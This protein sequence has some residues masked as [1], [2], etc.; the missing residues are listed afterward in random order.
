MSN[1]PVN[2]AIWS[3]SDLPP[4]LSLSESGLLTGHPTTSGSYTSHVQVQTNWGIA[5]KTISLTVTEPSYGAEITNDNSSAISFYYYKSGSYTFYASYNVPNN[6]SSSTPTWT[7]SGLP[8]GLTNSSLNAT[9]LTISGYPTVTGNYTLRLTFTKGSYTASKKF[10]LSVTSDGKS[11]S[12]STSS[13]PS[14]VKGESYSATLSVN[15]T[16]GSSPYYYVSGLPSGLSVGGWSGT[17]SGTPS[18][19]GTST[20]SIY[21]TA[22]NY[23]S[24]TKNFSLYIGPQTVQWTT[25]SVT[26]SATH[27]K[28]NTWTTKTYD[29]K[30]YGKY[31]CAN[32]RSGSCSMS[33]YFGS[34]TSNNLGTTVYITTSNGLSS[35]STNQAACITYNSTT[36][37]LTVQSTYGYSSSAKSRLLYLTVSCTADGSTSS[38]RLE[39]T[40]SYT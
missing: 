24:A 13:L 19:T 1:A 4:G 40:L 34:T 22:G 16:T 33:Y 12:I 23:Y 7:I 37:I 5:T 20:I 9:S 21:A 15:N 26:L 3:S 11:I 28:N 8:S 36:G 18:S 10:T 29:L 32:Q 27:V 6:E 31:I 30:S 25:S 14:G 39:I 38:G 2:Y 17:I 35:S